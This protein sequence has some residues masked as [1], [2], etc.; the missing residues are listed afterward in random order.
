[1][2]GELQYAPIRSFSGDLVRVDAEAVLI[3]KS[4][5]SRSVLNGSPMQA[6]PIQGAQR[7][8]AQR[9]VCWSGVN[10]GQHC[11]EVLHMDEIYEDG[12]IDF[13]FRVDGPSAQ[14]DS[15]GPVWDQ[16]T[17]KAV[18]QSPPFPLP[19][20]AGPFPSPKAR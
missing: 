2:P 1:M 8:R 20:N 7:P 11:G 17:H 16:I 12:M 15:G 10:G 9:F 3:D 6:E 4:L 13:V 5:R 19:A 18:E 14:G